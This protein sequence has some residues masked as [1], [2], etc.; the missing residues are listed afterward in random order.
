MWNAGWDALFSRTSW[1]RY[2]PEELIR[3]IA[4]TFRDAQDRAG[5]RVLE[6][7]CG[8]GANLWFLAREGFSAYGV[9]GSQVA[10]DQARA[11]LEAE[12]LSATLHQ[13]DV[14]RLPF[15]DAMFDAVIDVECV[16]ANTLADTRRI[17]D[18]AKR[19]LKPGGAVFS[20][21]FATGMSGEDTGVVMEGEPHT[22]ERMPDGPLHSDYGVIRL[23]SEAEIPEIYA[24]LDRLS[25]DFVDRS[26]G[27]GSKRIKE[28]IVTGRK[29]EVA[30]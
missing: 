28:W 14:A 7:G 1:G 26:D 18:E 20:K 23:T 21:T 13:G 3:F 10:L 30:R 8:P 16:Y 6:L 11:R 2:P 5:V 12:G 29:P 15:D 27:G 17:L 25:W 9:D 22:Y 19:V 4:R 24:G